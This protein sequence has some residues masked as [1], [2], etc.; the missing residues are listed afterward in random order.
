M[1]QVQTAIEFIVKWNIEYYKQ[2]DNKTKRELQVSYYIVLRALSLQTKFRIIDSRDI[3]CNSQFLLQIKTTLFTTNQTEL[4]ANRLSSGVYND[5][6]YFV[7]ILFSIF[8]T[9]ERQNYNPTQ[10]C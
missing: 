7:Q 8:I 3:N 5:Q 2:G 10:F 4:M 1:S 6:K 9:D